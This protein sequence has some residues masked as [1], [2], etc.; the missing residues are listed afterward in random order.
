MT[1]IE[2]RLNG[3]TVQRS[4]NLRGIISRAGKI[5]VRFVS[6][7]KLTAFDGSPR[8]ADV[9]VS[10]YD[11]SCAR[12]TF[13]DFTVALD[14]FRSRGKRWGLTERTNTETHHSWHVNT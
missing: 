5:G 7:Q 11:D 6:V 9:S 1:M 3:E 8:G 10:F 13:A 4:K 14:W 12:T 2:I